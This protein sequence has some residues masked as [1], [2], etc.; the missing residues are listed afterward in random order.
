M[1]SQR[2]R[3]AFKALVAL[4][5]VRPGQGLQIGKL[6]EQVLVK[7]GGGNLDLGEGARETHGAFDRT[8]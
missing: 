8:T 6:A 2:A 3:Y 1:I 4:A 5:R 7:A